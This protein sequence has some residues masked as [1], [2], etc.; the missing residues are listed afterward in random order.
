MT[1]TLPCIVCDHMR[2]ASDGGGGRAVDAAVYE[3]YSTGYGGVVGA[4]DAHRW[5]LDAKLGVATLPARWHDLH[6]R[7][8]RG[9]QV[10]P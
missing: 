9:R 7:P 5:V 6:G 2:A 10:H 3:G 8:H 1:N 4:C